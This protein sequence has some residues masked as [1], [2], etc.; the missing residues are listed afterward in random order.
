M[1][2]KKK[3]KL[4]VHTAQK[5]TNRRHVSNSLRASE[6][7]QHHLTMRHKQVKVLIQLGHGKRSRKSRLVYKELDII[8]YK[9]SKGM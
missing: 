5:H 8:I 9:K 1:S 4:R 3:E 2:K 7:T 6:L